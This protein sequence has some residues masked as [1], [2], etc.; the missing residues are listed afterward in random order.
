MSGWTLG[1]YRAVGHRFIV[2]GNGA[3][4]V[5]LRLEHALSPL[6]D[7]SV[8]PAGTYRVTDLG[9]EAENR[10]ALDFDGTPVHA[11]DSPFHLAGLVVWHVNGS[12][13]RVDRGQHLLLHASAAERD[14]VTVLLPAPMESGK[15]T[16]VA[17]LLRAGY[18][19]VTDETVVLDRGDLAVT[20]FPKALALDASAVRVLGGV[21]L[22]DY[23]HADSDAQ[24][25]VTWRDLGSPGVAS[26]GRPG[27]VV[28]PQF[29]H[30][31]ATVGEP[32]G[33][34]EAVLEL[35]AST[36]G[37]RERPRRN[38]EVLARLATA[39]PVYRLSIGDLAEAVDVITS[40]VRDDA[41][42]TLSA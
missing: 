36:F 5:R 10:Y 13:V 30:G 20:A 15:T 33:P 35:A 12:V 27:L 29:R 4:Q 25:H 31:S 22:P 38:L 8:E 41:E 32:V 42:R 21:R 14:G 18:R 37:F 16:T 23:R 39:V 17:G 19:Y 7:P 40:L 28:F 3:E 26:G 1:P 34:A 11:T 24:Q 9:P 2:R 6:A